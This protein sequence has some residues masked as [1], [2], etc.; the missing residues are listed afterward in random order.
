M[1]LAMKLSKKLNKTL[2]KIR[3]Q[4]N[5]AQPKQ[6]RPIA[7][8][9]CLFGHSALGVGL[10]CTFLFKPSNALA[11]EFT[12]N[13]LNDAGKLANQRIEA[14]LKL[15]PSD[16]ELAWTALKYFK[17]HPEAKGGHH[18]NQ[19][20]RRPDRSFEFTKDDGSN[21]LVK[22]NELL[23][24]YK[25]ERV[26][27]ELHKIIRDSHN[28]PGKAPIVPE[29]LSW[30][31][32][33]AVGG[34]TARAAMLYCKPNEE[35]A[36]I[37]GSNIPITGRSG[38]YPSVDVYDILFKGHMVDVGM[39]PQDSFSMHYYEGNVSLLPK[40]S[41]NVYSMDRNTFMIDYG[42]GNIASQ[43]FKGII[44]PALFTNFDF[45]S[46]ATQFR[47]CFESMAGIIKNKF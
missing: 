11:L 6:I 31:W 16:E 20:S 4:R 30:S 47:S 44:G 41:E 1:K 33:Q 24:S 15:V 23:D 40:G 14:E 32:N 19:I 26:I 3:I 36:L 25:T 39:N 17:L 43:F 22:F 42:V 18:I 27:E 10:M 28:K 35:Y 38:R 8:A 45:K 29:R 13:E 21:F 2:S 46:M 7:Q 37:F 9:W 5:P 12:V 34:V